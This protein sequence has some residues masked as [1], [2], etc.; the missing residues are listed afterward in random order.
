MANSIDGQ[1]RPATMRV[2][3]A[4]ILR[5]HEVTTTWRF[6]MDAERIDPGLTAGLSMNPGRPVLFLAA[7]V[8]LSIGL[9][10]QVRGDSL[11]SNSLTLNNFGAV[12][13]APAANFPR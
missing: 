2:F 12:I 11:T 7:L 10:G 4:L 8:V 3:A 1:N 9:S 6:I 5:S 13:A